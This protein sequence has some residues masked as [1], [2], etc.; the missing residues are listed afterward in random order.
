MKTPAPPNTVPKINRLF[1]SLDALRRKAISDF[2][3]L[4]EKNQQP[5]KRLSATEQHLWLQL[6]DHP[7]RVTLLNLHLFKELCR[8]C[9][10]EK[11]FKNPIT[12]VRSYATIAQTFSEPSPPKTPRTSH[13][14]ETFYEAILEEWAAEE[15]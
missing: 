2:R 6:K 3:K 15:N 8:V 9:R 13:T 11:E 5:F 1:G 10:E 14:P 12:S 7:G 4:L